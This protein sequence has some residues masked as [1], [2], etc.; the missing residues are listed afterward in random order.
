MSSEPNSGAITKKKSTWLWPWQEPETIPTVLPRSKTGKLAQKA[1]LANIDAENA[2]NRA[3]QIEIARTK[4]VGEAMFKS[5]R[6]LKF[7]FVSAARQTLLRL[8]SI[9]RRFEPRYR[10]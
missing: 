5:G 4:I 2:L 8:E 3:Y 1:K 7:T 9:R 10:N 6:A